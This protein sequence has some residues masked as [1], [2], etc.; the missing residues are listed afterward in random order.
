MYLP[1]AVIN[2]M[3]GYLRHGQEINK[4]DMGSKSCGKFSVDLGSID[5]GQRLNHIF[6]ARFSMARFT[7]VLFSFPSLVFFSLFYVFLSVSLS[8]IYPFFFS[9]S[10]W[11]A[12]LFV[13]LLFFALCV[14]FYL[15]VQQCCFGSFWRLF[16]PHCQKKNTRN[17]WK[18]SMK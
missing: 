10:I 7:N 9:L 15:F 3:Y 16:S 18:S 2:W 14:I 13:F 1:R 5:C 12:R 4:S 6:Y 17:D 11:F 8:N